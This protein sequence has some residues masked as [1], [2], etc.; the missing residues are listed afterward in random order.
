MSYQTRM[1]KSRAY[2]ASVLLLGGVQLASAQMKSDPTGS[3]GGTMTTEAGTSGIE[4]TLSREMSGWK[5]TMKLRP[6]QGQEIA[7]AVQDLVLKG[8][9]ISF[10]AQRPR[11][12]VKFVG[13]FGGDKLSGTIE[14]YQDGNKIRSG[15]FA[16]AFGAAMPAQQRRAGGHQ[17]I[18][19]EQPFTRKALVLR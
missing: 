1:N 7:P 8:A 11:N 16:L 14:V 19:N 3:W 17:I 6:P 2:L 15:T 18:P 5:A 4:L 10:T 9:D 12:L 13:K